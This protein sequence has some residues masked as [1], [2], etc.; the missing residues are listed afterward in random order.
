MREAPLPMITPGAVPMSGVVKRGDV[1]LAV[2]ATRRNRGG[3]PRAD[4]QRASSPSR[5][6]QGGTRAS[7]PTAILYVTMTTAHCE[8]TPQPAPATALTSDPAALSLPPLGAAEDDAATAGHDDAEQTAT[9]W[10]NIRFGQLRFE[11]IRCNRPLDRSQ[12]L[13]TVEFLTSN[14]SALSGC[15]GSTRYL[16]VSWDVYAYGLYGPMEARNTHNVSAYTPNNP[17]EACVRALMR[18]AAYGENGL[19]CFAR[20]VFD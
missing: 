15:A 10:A 14:A 20:I 2:R 17:A 16:L 6:S 18:G 13:R 11:L 3:N 8:R 4:A 1:T 19:G 5:G 7:I 9:A 12:L